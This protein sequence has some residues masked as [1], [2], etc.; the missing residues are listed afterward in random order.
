M[1]EGTITPK[2]LNRAQPGALAARREQAGALP[3]I[4]EFAR[5]IVD[6][7]ADSAQPSG[8]TIFVGTIE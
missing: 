1:I 3:T 8:H 2:L 6:A 5:A 7:A 4:E